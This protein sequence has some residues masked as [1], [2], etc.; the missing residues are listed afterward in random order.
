MGAEEIAAEPPVKPPVPAVER[1]P[2]IPTWV[3]VL[4]ILTVLPLWSVGVLYSLFVLKALPD[5]A[6]MAVPSSVIVAVAP[7]WTIP[8]RTKGG[9]GG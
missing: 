8:R 9:G 7:S 6:W 4:T 2:L 5:V 1:A 3:R